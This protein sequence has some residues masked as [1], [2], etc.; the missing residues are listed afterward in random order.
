MSNAVFDGL[1]VLDLSEDIA[2]SFCARLLADYGADVLKVEPPGGSAM[3]RVGPYYHDDPHPE[4]SLFFLILN[5]N[6]KGIT[7]NLETASGR[8]LL[9]ELVPHVDLVIESHR[10]GH[11]DGLGIGYDALSA[12]NPGLVVTSITPFGQTGPYSQYAGE[13]IVS[14]AM[15]MVMGISGVQGR[16][17]L[18]HGGFQA[19]YQGGLFGAGATAMALFAQDR[20]GLGQHVDV[21]IT[22]CVASTMMATQTIYPFIGG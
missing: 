4:K 17:P 6:K 1:K 7:L 5:L 19:Q 2:G 8:N 15:G 12:V 13:E 9:R 21:S 20:H 16:P 14:Y 18:K 3:R 11:L 10:P 22:E